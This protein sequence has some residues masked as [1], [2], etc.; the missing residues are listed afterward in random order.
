MR[1]KTILVYGIC[2]NSRDELSGIKG[3]E[4]TYRDDSHVFVGR[5]GDVLFPMYYVGWWA[6]EG[7]RG[8]PVGMDSLPSFGPEA[9]SALIKFCE[10][11]GLPVKECKWWL[12]AWSE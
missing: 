8:N 1:I 11:H 6:S 3:L 5:H 9:D 10:D 12:L 7:K 2:Y 4:E